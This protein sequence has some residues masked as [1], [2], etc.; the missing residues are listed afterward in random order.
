MDYTNNPEVNKSPDESNYE[1]LLELYGPVPQRRDLNVFQDEGDFD[2]EFLELYKNTV[3]KMEY[4]DLQHGFLWK[5]LHRNSHGEF[6]SADL[7][8]NITVVSHVLLA[9]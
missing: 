9:D 6:L 8:N 1:F 3:H 2:P 4:E 5:L 7:G